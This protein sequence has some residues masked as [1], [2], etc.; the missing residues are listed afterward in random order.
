MTISQLSRLALTHTDTHLYTHALIHVIELICNRN[1]ARIKVIGN[2]EWR[3]GSRLNTHTFK[4]MVA[5]GKLV[6]RK[7]KEYHDGK[8]MN[9]QSSKRIA[10]QIPLMQ[11]NTTA[12][13]RRQEKFSMGVEGGVSI[14]AFG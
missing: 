7:W 14:S 10:S 11:T 2:G 12:A 9:S 4:R 5:G 6:I 1:C 13:E 3:A 8:G